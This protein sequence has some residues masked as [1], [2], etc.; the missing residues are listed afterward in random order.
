MVTV[1][2]EWI[3]REYVLNPYSMWHAEDI[4]RVYSAMGND[5]SLLLEIPFGVRDG[6]AQAGAN[7]A[8]HMYYQ[9]I[10]GHPM[11]GGYISRVEDNA[12]KFVHA[13]PV[14]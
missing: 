3:A 7:D 6:F 11:R 13:E 8:I 2:I 4:P 5:R 1:V 14:S 12:W 9:T 10:H